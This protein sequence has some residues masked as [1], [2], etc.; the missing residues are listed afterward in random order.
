MT[1]TLRSCVVVHVNTEGLI[2]YVTQKHSLK[3]YDE[4]GLPVAEKEYQNIFF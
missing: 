1:A 3:I 4:I 2:L